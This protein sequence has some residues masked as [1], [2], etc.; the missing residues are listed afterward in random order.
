[1]SVA[2]TTSTRAITER[3]HTCTEGAPVLDRPAPFRRFYAIPAP[4][5]NARTDWLTD[6]LTDLLTYLHAINFLTDSHN[7]AL[8]NNTAL[9]VDFI[10]LKEQ[11]RKIPSYFQF[12][13]T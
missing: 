2:C 3:V 6:W 13:M 5:T 11:K 1:M 12:Y 8:Q 7:S 10:A 9:N 4:N